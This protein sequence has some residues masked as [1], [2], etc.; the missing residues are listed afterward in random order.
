[1]PLMRHLILSEPGDRDA[2]RTD[3]AFMFGPDLLAA[4]VLEEGAGERRV[5]LPPGRWVDLWRSAKY[6]ERSGGLR[7]RGA[8]LLKGG[9]ERTLP[10]PLE[11]LPLLAHAGAVLPL[12]PPDVDSLSQYR[13][14]GVVSLEQRSDRLALL[15]FPRGRTDA[16]FGEN[17]RIASRERDGAWRLELRNAGGGRIDLQ[18]SLGALRD[19]FRPCRVEVDGKRLPGKRWAFDPKREVLTARFD[20]RSPKLVATG[21]GC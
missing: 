5:Y 16:R 9:A 10:A 7:L 21:K 14:K 17:G 3:D 1:M 19:G 20:G 4:P 11:E 6:H 12:L 18:A 15:A 2:A 8:K 13:A